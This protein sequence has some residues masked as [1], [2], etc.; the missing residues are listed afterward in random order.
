VV[1][2]IIRDGGEAVAV[3]ADVGKRVECAAMVDVT[4]DRLGSWDILVNNDGVA[5]VKPFGAVTEEEF[6]NG[7][8]VT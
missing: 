1:A 5:L 7:F 4:V 6:D 2:Q 8:Q 3:V